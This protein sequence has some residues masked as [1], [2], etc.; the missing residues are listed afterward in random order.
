[1]EEEFSLQKKILLIYPPAPI[2]NREDRCQQP[3]KELLVIP[4]LPPSDL[5]YMAAVAENVKTFINSDGE[6]IK[7]RFE[8][9]IVD[10][11]FVNSQSRVG[12]VAQQQK[13]AILTPAE[14][15][16]KDLEEFRPDYLV[17]NVASTTLE[18]DL[19][20][21]EI[22]KEILP[23]IITIAKGAHFLTSNTD[24]LYK[25]RAL[26]L[27]V[28][29][30]AEETLKEILKG[31]PYP[32]IKGLCYRDGFVAKYT[33]KR[34]FIK[35]LD[36]IPF[37]ARHLVDNNLFRRPD[38]NKVQAV[39]KVS[40][41]C[42]FHCFFCLATPVS[43]S[44][45]RV[46]SVENIVAEIRECV[47]KYKIKNFL[48]WSDVFNF[49][50]EWTMELCQAIIDSGLKITWSSNTRADTAD[51][52]MAELMYESGCR[53]VSIG[54]ESGSQY[55]LDKIGKQLT[56]DDIRN[57]V[58]VFKKAKIK[59]YNYFV[60]G[61]PWDDEISVEQT[62]RFAIQLDSDF[63]SFYTAT[64]LPGT[65]F[66]KYVNEHNLMDRDG[67]WECAYFYPV[68]KTHFL[69]KERIFELHKQA[70]KRFYLRPRFILRS[71]L[72]IRSFAEIKNYFIA[73][74]GILL[75]K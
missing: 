1:M 44:K 30:E 4:P 33:G 42:P 75:R 70:V 43:G 52:E 23:N 69:T 56:I 9:K 29:G 66:S 57:T 67:S 40:R 48:F 53:L 51:R 68:V 37:P 50:R 62:I 60:I 59:I 47:E 25:Y 24:V 3:V 71:L 58:K 32:E 5:M 31:K 20:V 55:I 26:D 8:A 45:V 39:I 2:M 27:V 36:K 15:F 49:D 61:L 18:N 74:V 64:P 13:A 46:R 63:I 21:L 19:S 14:Q 12:F 11:S 54:V 22:A 16:K 34:H 17:L 7:I 28:V 65:R 38:N 72:N 73:G 6:K 41:G 10:Y 35:N